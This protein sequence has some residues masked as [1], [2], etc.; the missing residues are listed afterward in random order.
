MLHGPVWVIVHGHQLPAQLAGS[1]KKTSLLWGVRPRQRPLSR[2]STSTSTVWPRSARIF[3]GRY[4][5]LQVFDQVEAAALLL[6]RHVVDHAAG[7]DRAGAR[8]IAGQ[9]HLVQP[10]FGQ[11]VVGILELRGR[12]AGKAD[13]DVAMDGGVGDEIAH[14]R[15]S[16]GTAR[17]CSRASSPPA[18]RRC[19]PEWALSICGI[20]L[21]S[22]ATA[23][24]MR[25]VM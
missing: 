5:F 9:V 4:L 15:T 19:R 10:Q 24:R 20:T 7:A 23:R 11:D 16:A 17:G 1:S 2:S 14:A 3:S 22:S 13:D 12:F 8:A 18:P 25:S 21:G 6:V